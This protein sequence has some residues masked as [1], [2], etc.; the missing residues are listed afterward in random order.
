MSPQPTG[1]VVPTSDGA[2]LIL[3]RAFRATID[4]V[5]KSV[6]DPNC[7]VRWF[8]RWEGDA[9]PG[10]YVTLHMSFEKDAAPGQVLIETCRPPHQLAV[11]MKDEY[12][13]WR[14]ELSLE[15]TGDVTTLTFVQHLT[16]TK[17]VGDTGPG[18]EYYLDMLIA[19][20][21][22]TPLPNF[23]DYYPAQRDYFLEQV[24]RR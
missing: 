17:S 13:D 15:Q 16:D 23:A 6:T 14:L 4:D 12:G 3:T 7:T 22:G 8:G 10:K 20:R 2:D 9:G 1:R 11:S 5:W 19:S 24:S 18:W 21:S